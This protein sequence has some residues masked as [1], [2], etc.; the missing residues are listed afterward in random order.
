MSGK[1]KANLEPRIHNRRATHEFFI[2]AKLE[3]GI[4]LQG[5]E[6]KSLRAGKAQLQDSFA[7]VE[8]GELILYNAHIDPYEKAALVTN[9][10]AKRARKLLAHK[11]EIKR[12][13]DET[14]QKGTTLIPLAMYFKGG[15][16]KV[17]IGVGRGK[18]Y[19]D[20]RDAIRKKE[21]DRDIRRAMT[22]RQ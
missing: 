10:E 15:R 9:H 16:V 20:K 1:A 2:T 14:A 3:C 19:H 17:E 4:V 13:A 12:L 21:M 22:Q 5:S 6:V 7:R 18:Q 8:N 11:R